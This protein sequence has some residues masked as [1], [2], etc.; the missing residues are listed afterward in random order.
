MRAESNHRDNVEQHDPPDS[1]AADDIC[2]HV[3][4]RKIS[5]GPDCSRREMK[6]V[7]DNENEKENSAP[8]YRARRQCRCLRFKSRISVEAC[9]A[10]LHRQLIRGDYMKNDRDD[11]N[12]AQ[13]PEKLSGALEEMR[14]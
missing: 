7:N 6:N 4:V 5:R 3:A 14:V 10:V 13:R 12:H 2:I 8:T 11:Q 9:R 1:K